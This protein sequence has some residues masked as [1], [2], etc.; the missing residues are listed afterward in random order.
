MFVPIME[1]IYG[2]S[3][4]FHKLAGFSAPICEYFSLFVIHIAQRI[5]NIEKSTPHAAVCFL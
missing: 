4:S 3:M 5:A 1:A 2:K